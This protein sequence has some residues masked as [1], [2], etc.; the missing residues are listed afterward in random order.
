SWLRR[1]DPARPGPIWG[2]CPPS[3][4]RAPVRRSS[5]LPSPSSICST[6]RSSGRQRRLMTAIP[7]MGA[8]GMALL[9]ALPACSHDSY[10]VV[11]LTSA[12]SEFTDVSWVDVEV[13]G[14]GVTS[15]MLSYGAREP[16]SFSS[17]K[18]VTL[19]ISFTPSRSG[20]VKLTVTA[21]KADRSCI[22]SGVREGASI[23][24]GDVAAVAV[25]LRHGCP[26]AD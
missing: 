22:G 7:L 18:G 15:P 24:K 14:S 2:T 11:T 16:L 13:E 23:K 9:L 4:P 1:R 17:T 26:L 25:Q 21:R 5:P 8:A 12:D 6:S 20:D 3:K 10:L 19:S